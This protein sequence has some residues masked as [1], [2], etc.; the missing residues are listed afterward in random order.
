MWVNPAVGIFKKG[1]K[2]EFRGGAAIYEPLAIGFNAKNGRCCFTFFPRLLFKTYIEPY[3]NK[4]FLSARLEIYLLSR[5][6][7][8]RRLL[9]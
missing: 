6:S 9:W 3:I 2:A 1:V 7:F 4:L 5:I 8:S